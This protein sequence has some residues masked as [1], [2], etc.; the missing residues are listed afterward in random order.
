[1]ARTLALTC[2]VSVFV[3]I[4][5][6]RKKFKFDGSKTCA[7]IVVPTLP[8]YSYI[9]KCGDAESKSL[10]RLR[11]ARGAS[12]RKWPNAVR[13]ASTQ[14]SSLS[15]CRSYMY[16]YSGSTEQSTYP[17][18]PPASQQSETPASTTCSRR[19]LS[20]P[21]LRTEYPPQVL[22]VA[23]IASGSITGKQPS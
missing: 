16:M 9:Y 5:L 19:L 15:S 13:Q 6:T 11:S 7:C 22:S 10:E 18:H 21:S 2:P 12:G 4:H 8:M 14:L 20:N 17:L 3:R 23:E 1:M